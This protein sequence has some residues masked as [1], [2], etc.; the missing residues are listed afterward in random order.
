MLDWI[1]QLNDAGRW[2]VLQSFQSIPGIVL[3][4]WDLDVLQM[5]F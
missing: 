5:I 2:P 1:L 3:P 4:Q